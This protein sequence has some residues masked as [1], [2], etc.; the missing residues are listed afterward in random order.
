MNPHF[1][2]DPREYPDRIPA[3]AYAR[4]DSVEENDAG[5]IIVGLDAVSARS[6]D[7]LLE[8]R[9]PDDWS[10]QWR[11][12]QHGG[13]EADRSGLL[14]DF[15][16]FELYQV[17]VVTSPGAAAGL[18]AQSDDGWLSF[19]LNRQAGG[20]LP[21]T[22]YP[23]LF[24]PGQAAS[25]TQISPPPPATASLLSAAFSMKGWPIA[26]HAQ[27]ERLLQRGQAHTWAAYDVGQ[28]SANGLLDN[29]G[30]MSLLHDIGC[31]VY[32]NAKTR[33]A[34]LELC[35]SVDAPIVLSHWDTDHWGGARY[36]APA[37]NRTAFLTRDWIVP[38]DTTI[39]PRHAA[40]AA[41]ILAAQGRLH[42][43]APGPWQTAWVTL[44]DGRT[45][46]LLRGSG[47]D[48]NGSGMVMEVHDPK[49]SRGRWL[50][51]G[52]VDYQFVQSH[53]AQTYTAM[54]VPHHGAASK[55]AS[56]APF[57]SPT[58]ARLVYS[59]GHDN[60]YGHPTSAC[61]SAHIGTGWDHGNWAPPLDATVVATGHVLAT[62][63]N[64][65]GQPHLESISIGWS[66]PPLVPRPPACHGK[67]C[68]AALGQS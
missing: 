3:R 12:V 52:D 39:G 35:T 46:R 62:A 68:N 15:E 38:F 16:K 44:S 37:A 41:S 27:I 13:R 49:G 55:H 30:R 54:S 7:S 64:S 58:Y 67:Q 59:F 63:C 22:V 21:A 57:P 56:P 29:F 6:A 25:V 23:G 11:G 50:L 17:E 33:P 40:F 51:T 19:S 34:H 14:G 61:M 47:S 60:T 9:S 5:E 8:Q 31:G 53:L 20:N 45:V 36:L 66:K 32:A 2:S 48:R 42:V 4:V 65:P 43:T 24:A 1:G 10:E 28:G 26:T 18:L